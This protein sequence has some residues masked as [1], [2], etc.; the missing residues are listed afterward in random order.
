[1]LFCGQAQNKTW[2]EKHNLC[3]NSVA[4]FV[5]SLLQFIYSIFHNHDHDTILLT[6]LYWRPAGLVATVCTLL[7]SLSTAWI[8]PTSLHF[9]EP[10][11]ESLTF[12]F[13]LVKKTQSWRF[14]WFS[15]ALP[16]LLFCSLLHSSLQHKAH[17]VLHTVHSPSCS[18]Q[19]IV[20]RLFDLGASLAVST[21]LVST[22]PFFGSYEWQ[23]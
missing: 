4:C 21:L 23:V 7:I 15:Q 14:K 5:V 17:S 22:Q 13:L 20:L 1:M 12:V 8:K 2:R 6:I 10:T 9:K 11:K 3:L 18:I 19:Y 16:P